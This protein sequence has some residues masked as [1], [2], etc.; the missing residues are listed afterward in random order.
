MV[1]GLFS[2]NDFSTD[3]SFRMVGAELT[4]DTGSVANNLLFCSTSEMNHQKELP[5]FNSTSV[6]YNVPYDQ[7]AMIRPGSRITRRRAKT[8]FGGHEHETLTPFRNNSTSTI[9]TQSNARATNPFTVGTMGPL[10]DSVAQVSVPLSVRVHAHFE[11]K[12]EH[13]VPTSKPSPVAVPVIHAM[14]AL[15]SRAHQTHSPG[16]NNDGG[17]ALGKMLSSASAGIMDAITREL[18]PRA[19]AAGQAHISKTWAADG[20]LLMLGA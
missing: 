4:V 13:L 3:C 8:I 20:S 7:M 10:S 19:I 6:G 17:T 18:L 12:A 1:G 2:P 16:V 11:V 5:T 9:E 14:E 15:T